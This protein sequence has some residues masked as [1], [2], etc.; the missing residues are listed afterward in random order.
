[1]RQ[2]EQAR[3]LAT[4]MQ[5]QNVTNVV[6]SVQAAAYGQKGRLLATNNLLLAGNQL[7]WTLLDPVLQRVGAL[8]AASATVVAALAPLGSLLTGGVLLADRQT[9]RFISGTATFDNTHREFRESLRD[10]VGERLWPAFRRRTDVPVNLTILE[11]SQES[12]FLL[13]AQ[14]DQGSVLI[15]IAD[16]VG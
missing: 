1:M 4:R 16:E 14:V 10:Q 8:D 5:I 15:R 6:N 2:A 7:F 3:T 11:D 9:V 12:A 13:Q